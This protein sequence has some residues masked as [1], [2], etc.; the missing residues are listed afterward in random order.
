MYQL[1]IKTH[2]FIHNQPPLKTNY[3]FGQITAVHTETHV[4]KR[5]Y[6]HFSFGLGV[7]SWRMK[8][9]VVRQ[10]LKQRR[11]YGLGE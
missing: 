11:K 5:S 3:F 9:L 6:N 8:Y 7:R 10:R 1:N 4:L 2:G